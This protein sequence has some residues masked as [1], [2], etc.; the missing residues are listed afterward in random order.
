MSVLCINAAKDKTGNILCNVSESRCAFQRYCSDCH[1]W[2][3][4]NNYQNCRHL[5][6]NNI[7]S[8]KKKKSTRAPKIQEENIVEEFSRPTA[9]TT[10]K[11]EKGIVVAVG[12]AF[13]F[14]QKSNGSNVKI[15]R[16]SAEV[17]DEIE[18]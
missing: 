9:K 5:K 7:M 2:K 12:S 11:K 6:E 18:I 17:G 10:A 13:M 15:V 8:E 3:M 1:E 4:S 14:V 16:T